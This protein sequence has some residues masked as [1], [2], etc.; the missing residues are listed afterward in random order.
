[1]D[2]GT[3]ARFSL[4]DAGKLLDDPPLN[5]VSRAN[6][7]TELFEASGVHP[8]VMLPTMVQRASQAEPPS[9]FVV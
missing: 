4:D 1:M 5:L 9:Y 3:D 7:C 8:L 6:V 2:H